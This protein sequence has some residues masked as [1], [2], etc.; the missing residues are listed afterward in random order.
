MSKPK[1][2]F[3]E[4]AELLRETARNHRKEAGKWWDEKYVARL[5]AEASELESLA[6][7]D[8][9]WATLKGRE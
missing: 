9:Y 6:K 3:R 2:P 1:H 8:E 5:M 4:T 7:A